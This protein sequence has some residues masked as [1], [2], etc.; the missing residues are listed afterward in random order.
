V[1]LLL[2]HAPIVARTVPN[3]KCRF[4]IKKGTLKNAS[5]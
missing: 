4:Y 3:K 2:F 1:F 5:R